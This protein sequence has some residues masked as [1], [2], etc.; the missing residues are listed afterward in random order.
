MKAKPKNI[1]DVATLTSIYRPGPL[2]ANVDK[3]YLEAKS[4]PDKID[5][6]HPLIKKVLE[7]TYGCLHGSTVISTDDG[8]IT[9]EKIVEEQ[10]VGTKLPSLN[11]ESG[12]IEQDEIVAAV[13]TGVQDTLTIELEDGKTIRLTSD[14]RVYTTRGWVEA[15]DLTVEDEIFGIE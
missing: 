10:L 2:A 9:I 5:Y 12:E 14:H 11:E 8:D 6:Q 1:I 4:T 7:P 15:G 3:L 13:C